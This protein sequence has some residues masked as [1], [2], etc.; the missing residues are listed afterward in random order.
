MANRFMRR[1][2]SVESGTDIDVDPNEVELMFW[3]IVE[4]GLD[5]TFVHYGSDLDVT[6]HGSGFSSRVCPCA[7]C[8]Q[9]RPRNSLTNNAVHF[10]LEFKQAASQ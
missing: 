4:E 9:C 1:F 7:T 3:N 10:G 2:F 6:S 8:L 5:D